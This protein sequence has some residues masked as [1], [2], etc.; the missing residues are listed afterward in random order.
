MGKCG[1]SGKW[2]RGYI[3]GR[4]R[5]WGANSGNRIWFNFVNFLLSTSYLFFG[6]YF[7]NFFCCRFCVGWCIYGY[8][9]GVFGLY[10]FARRPGGAPCLFGGILRCFWF[11]KVFWRT[12]GVGYDVIFAVFGAKQPEFGTFIS[13]M[14]V[15][16]SRVEIIEI[17]GISRVFWC[18]G[19]LLPLW[20][21]KLVRHDSSGRFGIFRS[22]AALFLCLFIE[23]RINPENIIFWRQHFQKLSFSLVIKCF[24]GG[25]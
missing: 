11:G 23:E 2:W 6:V 12:F 8:L 18:W 13:W 3:E 5:F 17:W 9:C 15:Y 21:E 16:M 19:I 22:P 4:P 14:R 20:P 10:I 25:F 24:C 1:K 7:L